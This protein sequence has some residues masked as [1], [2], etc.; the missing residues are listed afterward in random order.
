MYLSDILRRSGRTLR[1]AK[2]RTLL[3]S[4]AIAVGTF[5]LTLTLAASNGAQKFVDQ[6][7]TD[8]F[9]PAEL[10]VSQDDQVFGQS[11]NNTPREYDASY[12]AIASPAG[13]AAQIKRLTDDDIAELE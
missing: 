2:V 12:G 13:A 11:D 6:I 7:I 8:N 4:L 9:D 3:T 1:S 10:I 5:S